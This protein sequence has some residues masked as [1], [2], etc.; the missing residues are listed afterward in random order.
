VGAPGQLERGAT[1]VG[2]ADELEVVFAVDED[3]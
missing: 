1:V 2:L 3:P